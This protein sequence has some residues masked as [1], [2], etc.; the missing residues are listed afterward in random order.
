[1][2]SCETVYRITNSMRFSGW[3]H[4]CLVRNNY[5][6]AVCLRHIAVYVMV[7]LHK[8]RVCESLFDHNTWKAAA[9]TIITYCYMCSS[10][11]PLQNA[12]K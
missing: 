9:S 11:V 12:N 1:M 6:T 3:Q 4:Y 2:M 10:I 7:S 8:I 5:F